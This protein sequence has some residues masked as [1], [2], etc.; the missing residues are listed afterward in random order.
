MNKNWEREQIDK[1]MLR[2]ANKIEKLKN[3]LEN[4]NSKSE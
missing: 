2:Q 3:D 1:L 4:S